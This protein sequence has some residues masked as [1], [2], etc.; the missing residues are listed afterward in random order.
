MNQDN[1][2]GAVFTEVQK[3][4]QVWLWVLII[5]VATI[6]WFLAI[7]Q[8]LLDNPFGD[9]LVPD[10]TLIVFWVLF[11]VGFPAIFV[12]GGLRTQV[13]YDA[14]YVR[15]VPFHLTPRKLAFTDIKSCE[16]RTYH[17]LKEYGGWGI[18]CGKGGWS[19]TVGGDRG[20]Q[21]E[22]NNGKRLLIGS[23]RA[24]EFANAIQARMGR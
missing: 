11:G 5:L 6:I 9:K 15:F 1:T 22:F 21:L 17:A 2:I 7:T 16:A 18:K 13:R 20:V 4:G 24:E 10:V 8:F 3:F 19:Y 14:V 23:K 12:F